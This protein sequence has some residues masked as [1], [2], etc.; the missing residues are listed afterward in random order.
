MDKFS[1]KKKQWINLF[2]FIVNYI[3]LNIY[4]SLYNKKEKFMPKTLYEHT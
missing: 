1:V 3:K 2:I 4:A